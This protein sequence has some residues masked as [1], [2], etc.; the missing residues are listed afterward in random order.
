MGQRGHNLSRDLSGL[1]LALN[2]LGQNGNTFY[3]FL[4]AT[5]RFI[6]LRVLR[7]SFPRLAFVR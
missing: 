5:K 6:L 3:F 1:V 4:E 2:Y 7:T